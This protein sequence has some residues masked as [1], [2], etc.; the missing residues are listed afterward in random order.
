MMLP[1]YWE[2]VLKAV[3]DISFF[4]KPGETLGLV[5]EAGV[6][7]QPPAASSRLIEPSSGTLLLKEIS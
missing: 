6:G 2:N 4:I 1:A 3:D 7:N 5:G